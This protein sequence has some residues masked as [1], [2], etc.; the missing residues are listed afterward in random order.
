M[1]RQAN[2]YCQAIEN[3]MISKTGLPWVFNVCPTSSGSSRR[4]IEYCVQKCAALHAL[5]LLVV[6]SLGSE[7]ALAEIRT[8]IGLASGFDMPMLQFPADGKHLLIWLPSKYGIRAGNEPF[9]NTVQKQGID[10]WLI[11]LHESHLAPTGRHAYVEFKPQHIKELIDYAVCQGRQGIILGGESRGTALAMMAARQ[12]QIANPGETMLKALVVYH[13]HVIEGHT[14]IGEQATLLAIAR[15]T[16]LPV[17]IFQP[18]TQHHTATQSCVDQSITGRWRTGLF[19]PPQRGA[20]RL[21][22]T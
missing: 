14:E 10:Y 13:P 5:I 8:E 7:M 20:G 17:Y 16:N 1:P 15:M 9:A 19:L 11:D 6:S 3:N 12:W 21:P 22:L 18:P 4:A 2:G